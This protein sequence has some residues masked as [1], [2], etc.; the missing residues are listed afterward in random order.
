ML[1]TNFW[2][3]W[4][5]DDEGLKFLAPHWEMEV[6]ANVRRSINRHLAVAATQ[7]AGAE[8]ISPEDA[9]RYAV[10]GARFRALIELEGGVRSRAPLASPVVESDSG[11]LVSLV[12]LLIDICQRD[13]L[14]LPLRSIES[15]LVHEAK[16][17][18]SALSWRV[19]DQ[20]GVR[21]PQA[22]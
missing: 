4:R 2:S 19:P 7:L 12:D 21:D 13:Q 20:D 10:A 3:A 14:H 5:A 6:S 22:C 9:A 16:Q 11:D 8:G 17:L 18:L 1:M 15:E